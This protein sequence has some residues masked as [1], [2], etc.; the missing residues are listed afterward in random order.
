MSIHMKT[1]DFIY[2]FTDILFTEMVKG[3]I[4][5]ENWEEADFD[6]RYAEFPDI[7]LKMKDSGLDTANTDDDILKML[8][9]SKNT[10]VNNFNK[11]MRDNFIGEFKRHGLN[12]AVFNELISADILKDDKINKDSLSLFRNFEEKTF[13]KKPKN[14]V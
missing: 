6:Y 9:N 12:D 4:L 8:H 10:A 13:T 14:G 11:T 7:F 1:R 5:I 3:T 2:N